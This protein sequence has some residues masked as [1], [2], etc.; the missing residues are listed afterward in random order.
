M[1]FRDFDPS[2]YWRLA[3]IYDTIFPER[4]RSIDEWRFYDDSLDK[5]KYYFKRFTCLSVASGEV[6][7]FGEMWNPPWMFH[8][9]KFWLD[10]W[11]DPKH[12]GQG[13]GAAIYRTLERELKR[14]GAIVAWMGIREDMSRPVTFARRRG[15][16]EKMR[17]WESTINPSHVDTTK[18]E[19]YSEKASSAGVE[20]STLERELRE[21]QECYPKLY[22]LV[23]TAFRDVPI[24]DTPTDTP[25]EQWI[26]FE[27]KNPNLVPEGYIIAKHHDRYIG[28]SVVWRLKK[29]PRS[30]YQGLTGVLRE[31]RGKG[32][33]MALKLRVLD[34]ARTNGFDNI[35][36]FNASTNEGMLAI[37]AKL[38]FKRDSAWITFEKNLA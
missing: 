38:G 11:V 25:Y 16:G 15:F 8:P 10:G 26:T 37:N 5:S 30:L 18:F 7:G 20:F 3:E 12:Q 13:V 29:E 19:T 14:H 33:A 2:D 22:E 36:T 24:A 28:T 34:F 6:L 27:M 4:S 21:D 23:Q 35:R 17:G 31:F 32:I 9:N 1:E